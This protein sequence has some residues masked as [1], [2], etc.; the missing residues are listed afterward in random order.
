MSSVVG[1]EEESEEADH[2]AKDESGELL[3]ELEELGKIE[4]EENAND[5]DSKPIEQSTTSRREDGSYEGRDSAEESN[6]G[7]G[8]CFVEEG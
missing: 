3:G 8:A 7:L 1:K 6:E 2:D 5:L 4:K